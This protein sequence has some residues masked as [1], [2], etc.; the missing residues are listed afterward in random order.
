MLNGFLKSMTVRGM[1]MH[2]LPMDKRNLGRP[3]KKLYRVRA[4]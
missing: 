4:D 1:M 2:S 3:R